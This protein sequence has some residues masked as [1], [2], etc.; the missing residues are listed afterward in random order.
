MNQT[1]KAHKHWEEHLKNIQSKKKKKLCLVDATC[2]NGHD[3]LF[4]SKF[5]NRKLYC[6]DIQSKAI[7]NTKTLLQN[8]TDIFFFN[9][10]HEKLDIISEPIGIIF[11]KP[12]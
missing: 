3:S 5:E 7:N 4:L 6:I 1:Q 8:Q 12:M 11:S 9:Q 2:G 10:S